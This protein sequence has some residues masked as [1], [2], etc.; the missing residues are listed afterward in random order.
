MQFIV[1]NPTQ[2]VPLWTNLGNLP[3]DVNGNFSFNLVAGQSF[4]LQMIAGHTD[5]TRNLFLAAYSEVFKLPNSNAAFVQTKS[6]Q[7]KGTFSWQPT[8]ADIRPEPYKVVF[9]VSDRFFTD[10]KSVMLNVT[11]AIGNAEF[12]VEEKMSLYPNPASDQVFINLNSE[13]SQDFTLN[14][15]AING[16]SVISEKLL[17]AKEGTN[18]F[19]LST[20]SW[21]SGVYL[22]HISGGNDLN[23]QQMLVIE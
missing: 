8:M 7:A 21:S 20:S 18:I 22:I 4:N 13:V 3:V 23:A 12:T 10:D 11:T 6:S 14:V 2:G 19:G 5:S 9:R 17:K 16:Q 15:I 1:V